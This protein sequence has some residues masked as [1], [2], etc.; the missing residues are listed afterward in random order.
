MKKLS[1]FL[2]SCLLL[3]C[4]GC[5]QS[6]MRFYE[7]AGGENTALNPAHP[8]TSYD[9]FDL[10]PVGMPSYLDQPQLVV[11]TENGH[12]SFL[13]SERWSAPLSDEV[14]T[15]IS[16][17][18]ASSLGVPNI[19]GLPRPSKGQVLRVKVQLQQL[20]NRLDE[21]V[22]LQAGWSVTV[23]KRTEVHQVRL[24]EK[25]MA[26]IEG[27]VAAERRIFVHLAQDIARSALKEQAQ[28]SAQSSSPPN[29]VAQIRTKPD[30]SPTTA[31]D[32]D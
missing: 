28:A 29:A 21:G 3:L 17:Q 19:H 24:S 6:P 4:T 30:E 27:M 11:Q 12:V 31:D 22:V 1:G 9:Y 18:L 32:T 15:L 16:T 26:G 14:Y 13:E 10:M 7:L 5:A 20:E 23:G 8:V 2:A 25:A